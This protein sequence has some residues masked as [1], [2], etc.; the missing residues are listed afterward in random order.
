MDSQYSLLLGAFQTGFHSYKVLYRG[1]EGGRGSCEQ[2]VNTILYCELPHL[3]P[4]QYEAESNTLSH[5][6]PPVGTQ[7]WQPGP[8]TSEDELF[9]VLW[10]KHPFKTGLDFPKSFSKIKQTVAVSLGPKNIDKSGAG[11]VAE[12]L[13]SRALLQAAQCFVGSSPGRGHGTAH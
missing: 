1:T 5:L 12:W 7:P 4:E 6:Y 11:P 2:A 3:K 10:L 8:T 9:H 13:S